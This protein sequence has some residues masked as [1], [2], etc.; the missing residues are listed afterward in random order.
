[1]SATKP[2]FICVTESWLTPEISD[3]MIQ[4]TG[5]S[6]FRNDRRESSTDRRRGGGTIT[7]ASLCLRAS[8]I[9]FPTCYIKPSGIECNFVKFVDFDHRLAYLL[10]LYIPPGL[11]SDVFLDLKQYVIDCLD[12]ILSTNPEAIL[13]ICGDFNQYD[14]SFLFTHFELS[15]IV[16]LPTFGNNTLDKFFCQELLSQSFSVETAPPLG[17]AVHAH[18]IVFIS[19]NVQPKHNS[20]HLQKVYDLRESHVSAFRRRIVSADWS[21]LLL[22]N[23]VQQ[24]VDYFYDIFNYSLSVIPISFVKITPKTKARISPV[25]IDLIN[26]R[27]SAYRAKNFP[28]FDNYKRKV[29]SE[30]LKSKRLWSQKMCNSPKG[31]WSVVSDV[32]GK[33]VHSPNEITSL[34]DNPTCA[35]ESVNLDFC[36][37]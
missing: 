20:F 25:I 1:V 36:K 15:N 35:A 4:I 7:Y 3:A 13:F 12:Y 11:K 37:I 24:C 32:S 30:I 29:K 26:K 17:N 34:F 33:A 19:R 28:V 22:C 31:F 2:S 10:C 9:V 27:W 18:N 21:S 16:N 8:P 5:Y 6:F 14:L 23:D